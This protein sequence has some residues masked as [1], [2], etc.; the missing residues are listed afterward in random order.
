MATLVD[1]TDISQIPYLHKWFVK[2]ELYP[3][4]TKVLDFGCG[5]WGKGVKYLIDHGYDAYGYDPFKL[6]VSENERSLSK[7]PYEVVLVSNVLNVISDDTLR[8]SVLLSSLYIGDV[9]YITIYE[10]NRSGEGGSTSK[11][12]Q[13]NTKLIDVIDWINV[14][15]FCLKKIIEEPVDKM[16][17]SRVLCMK[18][19]EVLL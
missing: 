17:G 14:R 9:V 2:S 15:F 13:W 6:S 5:R 3:Y 12:W 19:R 1:N 16:P 7:I 11:G 4:G 10:G 18:K 8:E